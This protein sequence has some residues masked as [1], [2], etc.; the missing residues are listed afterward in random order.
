MADID[1]PNISETE[2]T[3]TTTVLPTLAGMSSIL[4][5][6]ETKAA[7]SPTSDTCTDTATSTTFSTSSSTTFITNASTI[8]G[9]S[10]S[11][12]FTTS[13]SSTYSSVPAPAT[14]VAPT[15][16]NNPIASTSRVSGPSI[17]LL[18]ITGL[19][20]ALG[21]VFATIIAF[22]CYYR[23]KRKFHKEATL[24]A[25]RL[26]QHKSHRSIETGNETLVGSSPSGGSFEK[27][28]KLGPIFPKTPVPHKVSSLSSD[29]AGLVYHT[30][31]PRSSSP[32]HAT[33]QPTEI[34]G[35]V[36][37]EQRSAGN[38]IYGIRY[39]PGGTLS[40]DYEAAEQEQLADEVNPPGFNEAL[41]RLNAIHEAASR[42]ELSHPPLRIVKRTASNPKGRIQPSARALRNPTHSD[43]ES[44]S[45]LDISDIPR[46]RDI[47]KRRA[48][49][50]ARLEGRSTRYTTE[51]VYSRSSDGTPFNRPGDVEARPQWGSLQSHWPD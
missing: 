47:E 30:Y 23:R 36:F 46:D 33:T 28:I 29:T 45:E 41:A 8:S 44:I 37:T 21:I 11:T 40:V 38:N 7:I 6:S 25:P 43:L 26:L 5:P 50:L 27:D 1:L 18:G 12:P 20:V 49:A 16:N 42:R 24:I 31:M 35:L 13:S 51:S 14:L 2:I 39:N 3:I 48:A 17:S 22:F 32:T 19:S 4:S 10:S 15:S 34:L 9:T